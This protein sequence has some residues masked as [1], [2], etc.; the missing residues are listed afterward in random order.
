MLITSPSQPVFHEE[1]EAS[2]TA[3]KE[4]SWD[5]NPSMSV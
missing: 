3:G 4:Q 2:H 5:L 1:A